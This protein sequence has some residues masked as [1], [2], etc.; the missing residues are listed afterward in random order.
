MPT[1]FEIKKKLSIYSLTSSPPSIKINNNNN[2][3][4]QHQKSP[5]DN[6]TITIHGNTHETSESRTSRIMNMKPAD[7]LKMK[8]DS[9]LILADDDDEEDALFNDHSWFDED[10]E[11]KKMMK[12]SS[13]FITKKL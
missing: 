12:S 1:N 10:D 7:L 5:Y 4:L 13:T 8:F 2:N 9:M 3:N 11:L 6:I